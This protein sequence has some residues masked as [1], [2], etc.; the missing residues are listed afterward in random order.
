[1]KSM[2]TTILGSFLLLVAA[3]VV[4][5]AQQA[6]SDKEAESARI[7]QPTVELAELLGAVAS[8]ED[9]TF[10]V[11]S[12]VP[13]EVVVGQVRTRDVSYAVLLTVL[14]NNGLAAV[15]AEDHI[16]VIRVNTVRQHKLPLVMED[17]DSIP[18]D[19][20]VMRIFR[21]TNVS[22]P[23]LVPILRPLIV[24]AGHLA[25]VSGSNTLVIVAPYGT[26][27]QLG[28]LIRIFDANT[29]PEVD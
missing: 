9:K 18:D 28:E 12:R 13:A 15:R 23:M 11:D 5:I 29:K 10:L 6:T 19:E 20:W 4:V 3:P 7:Q 14:R 21:P 24:Q 1:M 17:D 26:V 22:A 2:R 25:A 27:K 16:S 8:K